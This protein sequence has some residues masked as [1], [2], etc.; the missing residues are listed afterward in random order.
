MSFSGHIFD[1]IRRNKEYR[2]T[3]NLRRE[4]IRNLQ[5][6]MLNHGLSLENSHITVEELE[7]IKKQTE[8]KERLEQNYLFRMK[9]LI[10]GIA[11]VAFVLWYF[12]F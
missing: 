12:L 6:K 5:E 1:M 2:D 7:E 4:R 3:Q 8:S 11:L 9:L 10:F